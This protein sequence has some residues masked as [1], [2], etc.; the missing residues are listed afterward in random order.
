[1]INISRGSVIDENSLLDALESGKI[2]GAGLDVFLNEP[3]IN[4]RFLELNNVF[5]QPHQA[6]ATKKTRK[7]MGELQFRNILNY[8]ENGTPL[9][10]VPELE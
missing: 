9:T 7:A 1:M 5:L 6:S 4:Q 3:R 10:L 8:F 2:Y